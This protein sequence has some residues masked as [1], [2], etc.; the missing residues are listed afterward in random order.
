MTK[1]A[2][3]ILVDKLLVVAAN[4][5]LVIRTDQVWVLGSVSDG[6]YDE[7]LLAERERISVRFFQIRSMTEIV[8]IQR[9]QVECEDGVILK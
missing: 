1:K 9:Q 6:V 3:G 5:A 7:I 2:A 4:N 8:E